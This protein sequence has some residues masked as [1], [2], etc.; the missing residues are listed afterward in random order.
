MTVTILTDYFTEEL[1]AVSHAATGEKMAA[2]MK[3]HFPFYGVNAPTR[4]EIVNRLWRTEKK[5]ISKQ[6]R[7][8]VEALWQKRHREYQMVALELLGKCK[9]EL[10]LSDLPLIE[11]LITSKSW[12]DTV[13]FLAS[14]IVGQ[15]LKSDQVLASQVAKKYMASDSMWLQRTAL[16]FQLKYKDETNAQLLLNCIDQTLGSK[17]FFINKASGWALRQYSKFNPSLVSDYIQKNEALLS[18]LTIREGSKYL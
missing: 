15:I 16:I 1:K 7:P 12:W 14:T 4:K 10:T 9:R 18:K 5:T 8:L 3:N 2:Y 17:E 6:L 13:D 11:K